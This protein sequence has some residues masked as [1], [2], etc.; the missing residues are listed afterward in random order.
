MGD[1]RAD[2]DVG[3]AVQNAGGVG[4]HAVGDRGREPQRAAEGVDRGAARG[5]A[6]VADLQEAV[7]ADVHL[8][9]GPVLFLAPVI[10]AEYVQRLHILAETVG[11]RDLRAVGAVDHM[12]IRHRGAVAVDEEAGAGGDGVAVFVVN[13][14]V[15]H[16]RHAAGIEL[17]RG[18]LGAFRAARHEHGAGR[19]VIVH[20]EIQ[21]GAQIAQ[22]EEV[23]A[24]DVVGVQI[25]A[26]FAV[27]DDGLRAGLGGVGAVLA[28]DHLAAVGLV[29]FAG[30]DR[31]R[32]RRAVI[33]DGELASGAVQEIRDVPQLEIVAAVDVVDL[34]GFLHAVHLQGLAGQ[35][36]L[37]L[38]SKAGRGE[39]E[40]Q[41]QGQK[42]RSYFFHGEPPLS[43]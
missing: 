1:G 16:R 32:A 4:D 11:E 42:K 28:Q 3:L 5:G 39:R 2:L 21:R 10:H 25:V 12:V 35:N 36:D 8:Q 41:K 33:A 9:H 38:R 22:L 40:Q 7:A 18:Q 27:D 34:A 24:A 20:A 43:S 30:G 15:K 26:R 31:R 13:L 14:N 23:V 37:V 17:L 19:G 29:G 6:R